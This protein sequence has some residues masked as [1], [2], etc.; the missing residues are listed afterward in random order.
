MKQSIIACL[1]MVFGFIQVSVG[2]EN[3]LSGTITD[4]KTGESLFG[5][6]IIAN[7]LDRGTISNEYGF[8]NLSLPPGKRTISFSY[9]GYA[10]LEK[11][12]EL[13]SSTVLS[14]ELAENLE[15][16][17]QVIV[18]AEAN[19]AR[20]RIQTPQ[21]SVTSLSANT[22]KKAPVVLGE[23]DILK[24]ITLLPGITSAGE[25]ASGFNVRGGAADQNLVLLDE[26]T[27]YNTSHLFGFFS[28]FNADAIKDIKLYKGGMPAKFGGRVASVLDVRQ[29]DG[30]SKEFHVNGGI[31]LISSR[32]MAEGPIKKDVGS[33]LV[34]GRSS[35]VNL[36]LKLAGEE[37]TV[38]F[39]DLNTKLSYKLNENNKLFLSGYFGKDTF[40]LGDALKSNYGNISF[41]L[42]WNHLFNENL[43]SNLSLIYSKYDFVLGFETTGFEWVSAIDTFNVK[44]DFNYLVNNK[45]K[46]NFGAH[47]NS[48]VFNPG[49]INITSD[50]SSF[51]ETQLDKKRAFEP[52]VYLEA[53]Q[54]VTNK[55]SLRYGFRVSSFFRQGQQ[56]F[57]SYEND[58]PVVYNADFDIYESADPIGEESF[59]K[60][61]TVK[62]FV[63]F[64]P[65]ASL[66]Y[67]LN[68]Q[69]SLKGSY[70]RVNQYLHLISNTNAPTPLDVWTPSGKFIKPQVS[71]Q[72]AI[73]FFRNFKNETYS[74]EIES[75]YK[76]VDNRLDYIDGANLIAT[77][78]IETE[79]LAGESRAYGLEFLFRKNTGDLTGWLSY[80]I[81]KSEQR[82]QGRTPIE[83]GIN[84]GDWYNT[85]YDRT[86][87]ISLTG[88]YRFNDKWSFS[89]NFIFQT[90]RPT[91]YPSGQY[92]FDDF[93]V[94]VF[95]TRNAERLPTYH[96][97][98]ISATLTPRKNKNRKWQGQWI[99]G[100]YN[101]YGRR[102]AASITFREIDNGDL[103]ANLG[104][105]AVKTSIFGIMP[106]VTYNF[107]F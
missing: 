4:S 78:N 40:T 13:T 42:R 74:L 105:E 18:S 73:G 84:N 82:V 44:Y 70:Q 76:T 12:V 25:G 77:N 107:K 91:N 46:L 81:S 2:Q 56:T 27:I 86:H 43:F 10:T 29:K 24:T 88:N 62:S 51:N 79:V 102:N 26:A 61:E 9:M 20:K 1:A 15:T 52:S 14:V 39:Y 93:T 16:L 100:L 66:S 63:N 60:G 17:E 35:Y 72:Y 38:G 106:A 80:T 53:D 67:M 57:D 41:N 47:A 5:V 87:D 85:A 32:L 64:E 30:N 8:Y 59:E 65:R 54:A 99:F 83:T 22:I 58:Q 97:L 33:F 19:N 7:G 49:E 55:L 89:T 36:F 98:D 48:Y 69:T 101:A 96:R 23:V 68:N 11:E 28:V 75:Y 94:P 103:D 50:D 71:D 37:N 31:G 104:N 3:T 90:G 92:Q 21:M 34:A 45:L 6:T 95:T